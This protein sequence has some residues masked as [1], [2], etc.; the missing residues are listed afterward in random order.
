[1]KSSTTN[2][3]PSYSSWARPV[4][5]TTWFKSGSDKTV[6]WTVNIFPVGP[7]WWYG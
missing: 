5:L 4:V 7:V 3:G 6:V 2:F 1:M